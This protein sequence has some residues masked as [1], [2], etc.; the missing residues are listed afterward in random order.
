MAITATA[1][2][3][4]Q[5]IGVADKISAG[6]KIQVATIEVKILTFITKISN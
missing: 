6:I 4:A 5:N 1:A 2:I 3:A